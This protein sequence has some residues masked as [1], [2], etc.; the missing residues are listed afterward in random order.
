MTKEYIV[1]VNPGLTFYPK[2]L[3]IAGVDTPYS[4]DIEARNGQSP[5]EFNHVAGLLPSGVTFTDNG[6][7][8]ATFAGTPTEAGSFSVVIRLRD[9]F[10]DPRDRTY[11]LQVVALPLSLSGSLADMT[12][13]TPYS[14][15][16]TISGGIAPYSL[17]SILLPAGLS[18]SVLGTTITVSGTPT[19]AG[20]GPGYSKSFDVSF[21]VSDSDVAA[22]PFAQTVGITVPTIAFT[23]TFPDAVL[24]VPYD[25]FVTISGGTGG[26]AIQGVPTGEPTGLALTIE[27]GDELTLAGTPTSTVGSPF[28]LSAVVRDSETNN[29]PYNDTIVV[30]QDYVDDFATI[31]QAL[32]PFKRI[33]RS[34]AG[35]AIRIRRSSDNA[36]T[37]IGFVGN[38]LDT[39]AVLSFVGASNGFVV[40]IYDQSG[41]GRHQTVA[42]AGNQP[43]IVNAG[44][45]DTAVIFDGSNDVLGVTYGAGGLSSTTAT[46]FVRAQFNDGGSAL[47]SGVFDIGYAVAATRGIAIYREKR[48]PQGGPGIS[49]NMS[50]SAVTVNI[51]VI[52]QST[53]DVRTGQHNLTVFYDTAAATS[54]KS[55]VWIDG[56]NYAGTITNAGNPTGTLNALPMQLGA[57]SS[58]FV[59]NIEFQSLVIVAS[60]AT[61]V[62][63]DIEACL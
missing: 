42:S 16:L 28:S 43:R 44:V 36:E 9:V 24:D 11:T 38:V 48:I 12:V 60:D 25:E 30:D 4:A 23:G 1:C 29:E 41:N 10:R 3:P 40:T 57:L 47:V 61:S 51:R 22:V 31:F 59:S 34:Y 46:V 37:N 62:R 15:P 21:T 35:N 45:M 8:T 7:G 32:H 55:T 18:A 52:P 6:D 20:L 63:A 5:Y 49:V 33:V 54:A 2:F 53:V 50:S 14:D 58:G 39:A 17:G 19:G 56:T 26:Y 27:N 13:G